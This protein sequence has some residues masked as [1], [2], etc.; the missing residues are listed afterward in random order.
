MPTFNSL[1]V[2]LPDGLQKTAGGPESPDQV[3]L[4]Q[5]FSRLAY[6]FLQDRAAGLVPYLL[7]FEVVERNE[8]GSQAIGIFGCK[9]GEQ[10]Y[11]VPTFFINGQIKG[12]DLLYSKETNMFMPVRESWI[13]YVVNRQTISLGQPAGNNMEL[14]RTFEQPNF[15]YLFKPPLYPGVKR[16]SVDAVCSDL[17]AAW[18]GMQASL[19]ESMEKDNAFQV[20]YANAVLC[21]LEK[22]AYAPSTDNSVLIEFMKKHGGV[23]M[24]NEVMKK[25]TTDYNFAKAAMTLY[26]SVESLFVTEFDEKLAPVKQAAKLEIKTEVTEYPDMDSKA[27][28]RIVT[29]GFTV[30]DRRDPAEK[31]EIY[32]VEY[33][34]R[35]SSPECPGTYNVL[36][37]TGAVAPAWVLFPAGSNRN[38]GCIVV[39]TDQ[40]KMFRAEPEAL[41]VRGEKLDDKGWAYDKAVDIDKMEIGGKYVLLGKDGICIQPVTVR[42]IIAED[43]TRT[44]MSVSTCYCHKP[45]GRETYGKDFDGRILDERGGRGMPS[46]DYDYTNAIEFSDKHRWPAV[47]G[48]TKIV[49]SVWK[50]LEIKKP[51]DEGAVTALCEAFKPGKLSDVLYALEKQGV[52]KIT[53]GSDDQGLEYYVRLDD[54]FADHKQMSYKAAC[55]RLMSHFG[56]DIEDAEQMLKEAAENYKSKRLIKFAQLPGVNM[57][58]PPPPVTSSDYQTG[59]TVEYPQADLTRGQM[60]G[61]TPPRYSLAPGF[62]LGGEAQMDLQAAQSATDAA[63]AGQKEVFD[64]SVIAGLAKTYDVGSVVDTYVPELLKALDKLGRILFLFYWKNEEFTERYGSEDMAELEDT[65]RGVF[66]NFGDLVLKLRQKA[67]ESNDSSDVIL[68]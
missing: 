63:H 30:E 14:R 42:S 62:N 34:K 46:S 3:Q 49:P 32:E 67:I 7:G 24:V 25:L 11:Y 26:P 4:E 1:L 57:P 66:K 40:D 6:T 39:S 17:A 41:F 27:K 10:Y 59:A 36:L 22:Q 64:H 43:G 23:A 28:K 2:R 5:D 15:D 51:A 12:M 65:I 35:F 9:L 52:H 33:Q 54:Q 45:E 31:S 47:D 60:Y 21:K 18:N 53:V 16:G 50:A 56:L 20:A 8:D 61:V 44:R 38:D 13:N 19:A 58:Y 68:G 29:K 48:H 55:V 37:R